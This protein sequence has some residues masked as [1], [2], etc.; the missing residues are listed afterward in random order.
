M[1]RHLKDDNILPLDSQKYRKARIPL[2][3]MKVVSVFVITTASHEDL[4]FGYD[5]P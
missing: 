2:V 5:L 3:V 1:L 4:F